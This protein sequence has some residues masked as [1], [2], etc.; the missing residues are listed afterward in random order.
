MKREKCKTVSEQNLAA[1]FMAGFTLNST[2]HEL[3]LL[4]K[5]KTL[6]FFKNSEMLHLSYYYMLKCQQSVAF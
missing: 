5:L 2:E 6:S 1:Y 4:K 3:Q